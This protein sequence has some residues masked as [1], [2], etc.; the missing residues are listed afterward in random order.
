MKP[1]YFSQC[2]CCINIDKN[3]Y[4]EEKELDTDPSL[5]LAWT[6]TLS[7]GERN[8]ANFTSSLATAPISLILRKRIHQIIWG[9]TQSLDKKSISEEKSQLHEIDALKPNMPEI[10]PAGNRYLTMYIPKFWE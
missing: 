1:T 10:G 4:S 9:G 3:N 5:T 7:T 2:S 6:L 8:F